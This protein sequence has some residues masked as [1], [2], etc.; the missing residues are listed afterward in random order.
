MAQHWWYEP[1]VPWLHAS[2][3]PLAYSVFLLLKYR[4]DDNTVSA[5]M[6]TAADIVGPSPPTRVFS[7]A[8]RWGARVAGAAL[9]IYKLCVVT[10]E[11]GQAVEISFAGLVAGLCLRRRLSIQEINWRKPP[12]ATEWLFCTCGRGLVVAYAQRHVQLI[13]GVWFN[14]PYLYKMT[15]RDTNKNELKGLLWSCRI[16][17]FYL[18]LFFNSRQES[19]NQAR[20]GH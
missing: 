17:F 1:K 18:L 16:L 10:K 11:W 8:L 7:H 9:L 14:I 6:L 4:C 19:I 13:S 12:E 3:Q 2:L 5:V 20:S 15:V